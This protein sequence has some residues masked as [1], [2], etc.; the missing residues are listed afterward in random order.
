MDE[1]VIYDNG[2]SSLVAEYGGELIQLIQKVG[3]EEIGRV[4]MYEDEF[5]RLK[6]FIGSLQEK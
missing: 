4:T 6:E 1:K 3:H 2:H 5:E